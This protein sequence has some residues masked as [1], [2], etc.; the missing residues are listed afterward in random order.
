MAKTVDEKKQRR[1][2]EVQALLDAFADQYLTDAP[3]IASYI[4]KLWAQLG[5]PLCHNRSR[6]NRGVKEV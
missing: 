3:D 4:D 6:L 2:E 5:S 1:I